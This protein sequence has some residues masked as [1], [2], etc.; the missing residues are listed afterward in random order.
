MAGI[1]KFAKDAF[2]RNGGAP[3]VCFAKARTDRGWRPDKLTE[4]AKKK[5][6]TLVEVHDLVDELE[7]GAVEP[8]RGEIWRELHKATGSWCNYDASATLRPY[9]YV[10]VP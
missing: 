5:G 8:R 2:R 6:L 1:E 3:T 10:D 9:R 4:W 7:A